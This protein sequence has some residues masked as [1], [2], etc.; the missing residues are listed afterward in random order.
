MEMQQ[1]SEDE[2]V[3]TKP[4]AKTKKNVVIETKTEQ[5]Y[6]S[7]K[8]DLMPNNFEPNDD[9]ADPKPKKKYNYYVKK[10]PAED[11]RKT[12]GQRTPA[13][14]EALAKGRAVIQQRK[15]QK[16]SVSSQ[17]KTPNYV[18]SSE[19]ESESESSEE[20]IVVKPKK[21]EKVKAPKKKQKKVLV[22]L[23]SNSEDSEDDVEYQQPKT[24]SRINRQQQ[25][26]HQ[27]QQPA[28]INY[29]NFFV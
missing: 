13:Q 25:P 7:P 26:Q 12:Q 4:K 22:Y 14:L 28:P 21:R 27:Y 15:Q 1:Q 16:Q 5:I 29:T 8:V 17:D 18:D 2:N 19:S 23:S 3:L 11:G 10:N 6:P 24:K 20:E 9:N